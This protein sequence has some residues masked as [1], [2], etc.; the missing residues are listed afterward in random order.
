MASTGSESV[1]KFF[2][3]IPKV[4][5]NNPAHQEEISTWRAPDKGR[6]KANCDV[7]IPPVVKE[8]KTAV[9]LRDWKG[10]RFWTDLQGLLIKFQKTMHHKQKKM[11][12]ETLITH[13]RV[14]EETRGQDALLT[15]KGIGHYRKR[16]RVP[17][18]RSS[19]FQRTVSS[20]LPLKSDQSEHRCPFLKELNFQHPKLTLSTGPALTL[21]KGCKR[22]GKGPYIGVRLRGGRWVSEIR[23]P[24][25]KT[26]IWLGSHRSPEK[27][28]RAY[29]AALYCLKG[30]QASFNFPNNRRPNLAHRLVG[31]L[32]ID[33]IQCI[34][35]GFSCLDEPSM[36]I[37]KPSPQ[38]THL[39]LDPPVLPDPQRMNERDSNMV[40]DEP[41]VPA[42]VLEEEPYIP[43][44]VPEEEPYVPAYVT[45]ADLMSHGN[46]QLDEWLA[47][48][49]EW[50]GSFR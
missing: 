41:H 21:Q 31:S 14:K 28:A 13:I 50:M 4:H 10:R 47:Q 44:Y 15:Y 30:E 40:D 33:E 46:L 32:H 36:E 20:L 9:V 29:D 42:Y 7:A 22:R 48:D 16:A 8:G 24:K 43:T 34:A 11:S 45:E 37:S 35:A 23:I 3:E 5:T 49:G 39:L 6:F 38:V 26:R 1:S 25:T 2:L 12:M 18:W 17:F 27:A 19:H